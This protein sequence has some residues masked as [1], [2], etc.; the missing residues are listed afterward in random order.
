M[1]YFGGVFQKFCGVDAT[2]VRTQLAEGMTSMK[3]LRDRSRRAGFDLRLATTSSRTGLTAGLLLA[4]LVLGGVSMTRADVAAA[5]GDAPDATSATVPNSKKS[6]AKSKDDDL[7]EIVVTG[8]LIPR[9]KQETATP[10]LVITADDIQNK[11]F[12]DVADALQHMTFATGSIQGGGYSGGFTQGAKTLSLFGLNESYTKYLIDGRP[13]A[14]YPAL[15]NG[16]DSFVS[17]EGIPTVLVD[18]IDILPGGQSSIYGSDAIAGVINIIMKKSLDGPSADVRYGA[19]TAGGDNS[20]RLALADGIQIGGLNVVAGGQ[21]ENI[22]PIW[23]YQRGVTSQ[24]YAGGSSPQTA[25]R[26]W[27]V[28]GYYGQPNGDLYYFED[29]ANCGNVTSQF[30]GTVGLRTRADRGQ[31]CGTYSSGYYTIANGTE[32]AQGYLH[33]DYAINDDWKVFSD[34]ML[35]HDDTRFSTGTNYYD[36]SSD[37]SGPYYYFEDPA[38]TTSDYLNLQRIFSPEEAGG[39]GNTIDKNTLAG[40][41]TTVGVTGTL[42]SNWTLAVDMTY[43]ENKL[44][45]RTALAFEDPINNFFSSIVGP[46]LGYDS[47]LGASLYEPNFAQF[48]KAITP[49]QYASFSGYATSYSRTEESLARAEVLNPSLFALPG[50][51]AGLAVVIDG[52]DQGWVYNPDPAYLDGGTYLYTATSGS[53]H[54]SRYSG[55]TELKLPFFKMLTVDASAR[56]DAYNVQDQTV[57]KATYD[58]GVEFR[59][60]QQLLIRGRYGTAFKAPTL[61]DEYQG[62]SGYYTAV[63]DYYLC[64]KEGYTTATFS[65]CP[66]AGFTVFGTTSGNTRLKPIT[67]DVADLGVAW[68]PNDRSAITVDFMHWK[69]DNEVETQDSSKLVQQ[70]SSCLLGQL[71]ITSP[72]CVAALAEVQRDANG[73]ISSIETPKVNVALETL[74]V[75]TFGLNYTVPTPGWGEFV[76]EGAYTDLIKHSMIMYPGDPTIDLLTNPFYSTDFKS[77]ENLSVTW[78]YEKFGTTVYVEHYGQTPNYQAQQTALGYAVPD[79]GTLG[80]WTLVSWSAKYEIFR[81]LE[82]YANIDNLFNT[83]PPQDNSTPGIVNQP[84]NSLDYNP[85]GRSF[86]IGASYKLKK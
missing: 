25:E 78:N 3:E 68:S 5:A 59:P 53:G 16:T 10:L 83:M 56:Y 72:T 24:Y 76:F 9:I 51:N 79:G 30:Y 62:P 84:Y 34:V 1:Q 4:L 46:N 71:Q 55:T 48:Y 75:L 18:H 43:T 17:I 37:T 54:R 60:L 64:T 31:Y 74:D 70:D 80:T 47:A 67:A 13:I 26:D 81:G 22:T 28:L 61:A 82:V 73:V 45:E 63:N 32:E 57:D 7:E 21:Y 8:S 86:F 41:R 39:L 52:G 58:I 44:T 49:A 35:D 27:L 69:I 23:G 50:G 14:D 65:N 85:Y 19:T 77:K 11:G 12:V 66:Y 36:T 42:W 40:I 15:Y 29:P 33:L 2:I 6:T 20:K 38:V